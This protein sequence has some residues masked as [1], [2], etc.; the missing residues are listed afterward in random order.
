MPTLQVNNT[1]LHAVEQGQ[2][3]PLLLLHGVGGTHEMW[4]PLI[5]ELARSY[6]VIAGDHRGHGRSAKPGGTYT[7]RLFTDDWA[8]AMDALGIERAHLLGLSMGG[9]IAMRMA[10]EHPSRVRSLILVDTWAYPHPDFVAML[11]KRLQALG[12]GDLEAYAEAAIPQVHSPAFIAANP[13]AMDEYRARVAQLDPAS[14]R[15]AIQ[16]CID[17][18]MQGACA[19]IK[20]PTLVLVGSLDTLTPPYHSE[21]LARGIPGAT[22]S[23]IE[24]SG[25]AP[26]REM[27]QRFLQV[28]RE[29]LGRVGEA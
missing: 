16:A 12:A 1:A 9:A 25:H 14:A 7:V 20:A 29:F 17:H 28:V 22:L 4:L 3:P 26:N 15:A 24:G 18:D 21:Y 13:R 2:G 19:R 10:V 23:V 5:P 8:Q 11:R 27:P 6:R